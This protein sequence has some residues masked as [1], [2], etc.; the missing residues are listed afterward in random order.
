MGADQLQEP[1]VD[2][3]P[4]GAALDQSGR[5]LGNLPRGGIGRLARARHVI[6]GD[7]DPEVV[8]L[9]RP[10][11]EDRHRP[12]LPALPGLAAP[13]VAGHDLER[14]LRRRKPDAL[15]WTAGD[16]GHAF[17]REGQVYAALRPHQGVNLVENHHLDRGKD[18]PG[19][20]AENQEEGLWR[21]DED[22]RRPARH[23]GALAPRRVTRA[24]R[25]RREMDGV[26]APCG[27]SRDPGE[28]RAQVPLHVHGE[29]LEG[30]DVEDA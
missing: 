25:D 30:R 4:D 8:G 2:G 15:Q 11:L 7:L 17:H 23:P 29:R 28:G 3:G 27:L 14:P 26:A 19:V 10:R 5:P 9:L 6:D 21:R 13:Q 20:R 22:V 18:R 12:G 16:L 1:G 24:H